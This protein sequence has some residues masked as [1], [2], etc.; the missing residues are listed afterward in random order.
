MGEAVKVLVVGLK[1]EQLKGTKVA[2]T[3]S[4][5]KVVASSSDQQ[6]AVG[7]DVTFWLPFSRDIAPGTYTVQLTQASGNQQ[8]VLDSTSFVIGNP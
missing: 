7:K 2:L 5:G 8:K 6:S 4:V 3:N 1:C